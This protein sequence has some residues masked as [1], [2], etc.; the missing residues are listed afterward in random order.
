LDS[1][2]GRISAIRYPF[3]RLASQLWQGAT[4]NT[5]GSHTKAEMKHQSEDKHVT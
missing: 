1:P 4:L 2:A 5:S 3:L